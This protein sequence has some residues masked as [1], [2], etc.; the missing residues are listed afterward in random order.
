MK[1]VAL[2]LAR[3]VSICVAESNVLLPMVSSKSTCSLKNYT[4]CV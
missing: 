1:L 4:P 2:N 3:Y